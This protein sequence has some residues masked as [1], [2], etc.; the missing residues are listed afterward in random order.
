MSY[1]LQYKVV[2]ADRV[3][4]EK[5]VDHEGEEARLL[6]GRTI[7]EA[8]PVDGSGK[9]LTLDLPA[10]AAADFPVGATLTLPITITPPATP[11]AGTSEGASI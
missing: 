8:L 3:T 1:T 7:I 6:V 5:I 9:T 2:H 10:S 11:A 4:V